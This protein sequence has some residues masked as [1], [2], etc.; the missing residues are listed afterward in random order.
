MKRNDWDMGA[1]LLAAA[2][3]FGIFGCDVE[4]SS[5]DTGGV[6]LP[7]G[8]ASAAGSG[9]N[10]GAGGASGSGGQPEEC[11]RG[12]SV[13]NTDYQST[14]V[15]LMDISGE[16]LSRSFI[17]SAS[18]L[19]GLSA[20]LSG[21]VTPPSG[22][23][24][25]DELVL[26]D[27]YPASVLTWVN[28][29]TGQVRAQLSVATG[30]AANPHDYVQVAPDKAYITRYEPNHNSGREA[31]DAGSDLLIIDPSAAKIVGRVDLMPAMA[32]AGAAFFPRADVALLAGGSLYVLL[33]GYS[34]NFVTSAESRIVKL[35]IETNSISEVLVLNGLHGCISM[36]ASPDE[37][38]LGI[39][40]AGEFGGSS[41]PAVEDSALV[42][43]DIDEAFSE[44][45]RV[46]AQTFGENPLGFN[47]AWPSRSGVVFTTLGR[48]AASGVEPRED[49]LV[50]FSLE[51]GSWSVLL[52]SQGEAFTLGGVRCFDSCEVCFLADSGRG[53]VLR[54]PLRAGELQEPQLIQ[55]DT[56]TGLPP[57]FLGVY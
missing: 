51:D 42:F 32:S 7:A 6:E 36:A 37:R 35:D 16:V 57:R 21:D 43:V 46:P 15:S 39:G 47:L 8:G 2:G 38:L 3:I 40:C 34:G 5:R 52:S 30:F 27:R 50:E 23:A 18:T 13:I 20:P 55:V 53:R 31:F 19:P 29:K 10:G 9:G 11:P 14:N 49:N 48:R 45:L 12:I 26:I 25:G 24:A 33:A 17:S 28:L 56:Q 41:D 1:A 22:R 54:Y 44:H 4:P